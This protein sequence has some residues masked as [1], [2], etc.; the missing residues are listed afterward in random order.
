VAE[1]HPDYP[2]A[3]NNLGSALVRLGQCEEGLRSYIRAISLRPNYDEAYYNRGVTQQMLGR[4]EAAV[5]C[6]QQTIA[7][8]PDYLEAY[9]NLGVVLTALGRFDEALARYDQAIAL[10]PAYDEAFYNRGVALH[11]MERHEAAIAS[12]D[13]AIALRP[14]YTEALRNRGMALQALD[15]HGEALTDFDR[16][17]ALR[18]DHASAHFSKSVCLLQSGDL[19]RGWQEYEWRWRTPEM[20]IAWRHFTEPLWLGAEPIAGKTIL[21]HA[22]QGLGDTLQFCRFV[23]PVAAR[24]AKVILEV[25]QPLA[26]LLADLPGAAQTVTHGEDLPP[27]DLHCPLM[28]LPLALGT[29]LQTIPSSPYLAADP[30]LVAGWRQRLAALRELRVGVVWAG[31]PGKGKD[32]R[33]SLTT[34]HLAPL[35]DVSG[36]AFVSLQKGSAAAEARG[37]RLLLHDHT[38]ELHDFADTAALVGALDLVISVDTS[39]AHLAGALGRP[40]WLLTRFEADWRWMRG[41][42]DSP[43]YPTARLFRQS[44]PGDWDG[45]V[46]RVVEALR[47]LIRQPRSSTR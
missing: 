25:Q 14:D 2:E 32:F 28:S 13:Q 9:N 37:S 11:G 34:G 31:A 3:H 4:H 6:Y 10:D 45:V 27:F 22:E 42:E 7:L 24:G 17:I 16:A 1:Q 5:F 20:T 18:P 15:R 44:A 36:V 21:L 23:P 30:A 8:Q 35:A 40:L 29:T 41:C 26:R 39:V 43:W 47:E 12:Y 33:R 46:A 19:P 38:S